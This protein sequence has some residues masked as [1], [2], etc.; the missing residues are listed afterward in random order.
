MIKAVIFD[1]G[2]VVHSLGKRKLS[3]ILVERTNKKLEEIKP[4]LGPLLLEM[5]VKAINEDQFWEMLGGKTEGVWEEQMRYDCIHSPVVELVKKLKRKKITTAVL[6][7]TIAP[8]AEIL[9][10]R[11]WYKYFDRVFLSFEIGLRK[12][13]IKAYEHVLKEL[14]VTGEECIFIDDILENLGPAKS[15][16]IKTVLATSPDQVVREVRELIE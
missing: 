3:E 15:L 1:F 6:S 13:D 9:A 5:S 7:N 8:H 12:P 2:G 11:G 14:G 10:N 16:G 4:L